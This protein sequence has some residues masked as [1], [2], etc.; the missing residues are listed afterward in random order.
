[1]QGCTSY[2]FI[3]I[4]HFHGNEYIKGTVHPKMTILSFTHPRVDPNLHEVLLFEIKKYFEEYGS[5][6][7]CWY[8]LTYI[9]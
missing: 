8:P 9:V 5:P 2:T 1:M 3:T 4:V 6:N 7:S